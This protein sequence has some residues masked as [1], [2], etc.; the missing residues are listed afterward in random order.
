[1]KKENRLKKNEEF[2]IVFQQGTSVAN[3]QF[4]VYQL[5]KQD[6]HNIRIGLSVSK[7][8]GNAV[9][10]NRIKRVI[11]EVM[12]EYLP[13]LHQN[14]DLIIIARKPV[15]NMDYEEV[16]KSLNH[17]LNRAKLIRKSR[18]LRKG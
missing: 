10:R 15:T 6:Q 7:K 16:K 2:Q 17:V 13:K 8:L 12:K 9:T 18:P 1:M 14:Y 3:R 4:V 5:K 11:R